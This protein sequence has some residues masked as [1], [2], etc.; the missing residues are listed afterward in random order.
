[1]DGTVGYLASDCSMLESARRPLERA[2][3]AMR[4]VA[5]LEMRLYW[6]MA[7]ILLGCTKLYQQQLGLGNTVPGTVPT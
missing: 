3:A 6:E 5:Y 2:S 4:P 7:R 1:M